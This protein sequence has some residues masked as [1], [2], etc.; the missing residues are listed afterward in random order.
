MP[1]GISCSWTMRRRCA[2]ESDAGGAFWPQPPAAIATTIRN[3]VTLRTQKNNAGRAGKKERSGLPE[4]F[5]THRRCVHVTQAIGELF[6]HM[7]REMRVLLNEKM[8]TPFID[9]RQ[10]ARGLRHSVGSTRTVI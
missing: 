9:W 2:V 5:L 6:H 8:E 3:C 1:R 7:R 10:S 4:A